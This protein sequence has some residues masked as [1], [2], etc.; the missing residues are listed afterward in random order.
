MDALLVLLTHSRK[1]VREKE[2]EREK[3]KEKQKEKKVYGS[4]ESWPRRERWSRTRWGGSEFCE[5]LQT[6]SAGLSGFGLS[7]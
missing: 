2:R 6:I 4:E 3:E 1:E 7:K 5:G